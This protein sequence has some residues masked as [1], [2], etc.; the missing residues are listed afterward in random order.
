MPYR[1]VSIVAVTLFFVIILVG[2]VAYG[3]FRRTFVV[4]D[5]T[6]TLRTAAE[7]DELWHSSGLHGRTAVIFS[8]HLNQQFSGVA[9][10]EMDYMDNARRHGIVRKVY[11]VVPDSFWQAVVSE[12]MLRRE[13]IMEPIPTDTGFMILHEG[14]RIHTMPLSKYIPEQEKA[15]VVFEKRVWSQQEQSRIEGFLSS[16]QL[17]ADLT[18]L[19]GEAKQP[20]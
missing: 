6:V 9:F 14:I 4:P 7:V 13:F 3:P 17:I 15:I 12:N 5:R 8:R 16:G 1:S 2:T 11:Y 19:I 20:Q 18:I 10:P